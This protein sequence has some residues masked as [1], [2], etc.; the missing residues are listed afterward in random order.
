[1]I[2]LGCTEFEFL[3]AWYY[4]SDFRND[5]DV[6]SFPPESGFTFDELVFIHWHIHM[7]FSPGD[8]STL[9]DKNL[10]KVSFPPLIA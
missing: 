4:N 10:S 2:F 5:S 6:I 7:H 1:M 8:F 9:V 3:M